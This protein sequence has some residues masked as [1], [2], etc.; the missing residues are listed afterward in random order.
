MPD[1]KASTD[2]GRVEKGRPWEEEQG[3]KTP[4]LLHS[5]QDMVWSN[6]RHTDILGTKDLRRSKVAV[7]DDE[8]AK[9][10]DHVADNECWD[11][12]ED[13]MDTVFDVGGGVDV[14]QKKGARS[15][16]RED[17][18]S[19]HCHTRVA[20]SGTKR[21]RTTQRSPHLTRTSSQ[22]YRLESTEVARNG[23]T[24]S[25]G[26]IFGPEAGH[27]EVTWDGSGFFFFFF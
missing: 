21:T 14:A 6:I 18:L 20:A 26:Q 8:H 12:R 5:W 3:R 25:R 15:A 1:D 13:A 27:T 19:V 10:K 4:T 24:I 2:V 11:S 7:R 22:R 23:P 16:N 17:V 9:D